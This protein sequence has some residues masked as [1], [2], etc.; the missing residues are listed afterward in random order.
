MSTKMIA[1]SYK[2]FCFLCFLL[3]QVNQYCIEVLEI[4]SWLISVAITSFVF[5]MKRK[6]FVID[7]ISVDSKITAYKVTI[8][9]QN[10]SAN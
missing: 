6:Q 1:S 4:T 8:T 7:S 9:L 2:R 3:V 5:D 10:V